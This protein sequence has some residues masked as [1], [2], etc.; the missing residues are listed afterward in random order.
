MELTLSAL[1]SSVS[2][3]LFLL[4]TA[5]DPPSAFLFFLDNYTTQ[6]TKVNYY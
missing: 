2:C 6:K 3:L 4:A 1:S 5:D